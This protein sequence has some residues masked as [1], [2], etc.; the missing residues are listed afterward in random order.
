MNGNLSGASGYHENPNEL[1][2]NMESGHALLVCEIAIPGKSRL[3]LD[4][5]E[6]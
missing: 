4:H 3:I 5:A 1:L 6:H 2:E